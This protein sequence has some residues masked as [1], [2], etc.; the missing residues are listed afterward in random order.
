LVGFIVL[1]LL[2]G[3]P[4]ELSSPAG[5]GD[6]RR[7]K[8]TTSL[9]PTCLARIAA[10][11]FER[12]SE[13]WMDKVCPEHGRFST[14]L[15]SDARHYYAADPTVSSLGSCCGSGG[16]C[17]DQTANHSCNMLL[18]I[19]QRCNLTCPTCYAGSS[20][21]RDGFLSL[22]AF[23]ELLDGLLAKGKG[24]ADLVQLSGGEPT[25]RSLA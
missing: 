4:L 11:V 7:I 19:T 20:P 12:D 18:E 2:N 10:D 5:F 21:E 3:D 15:A 22:A 6:G 8:T 14:L 1:K 16:H 25:T 23:A 17:G 9:C 24:D 13:I